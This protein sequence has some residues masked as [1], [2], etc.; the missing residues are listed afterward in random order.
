MGLEEARAAAARPR[1]PF[2][3]PEVYL[4]LAMDPRGKA[5]LEQP[6]FMRMFSDVQ[7]D[8]S[9]ISMYLQDPRMQLVSVALGKE[10]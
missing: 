2:A 9:R 5:L 3:S 10:L 4:K 7:A 8:P 6:D 1:N